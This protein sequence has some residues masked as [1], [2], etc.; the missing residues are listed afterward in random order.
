MWL[1]L[2][3]V[4]ALVDARSEASERPQRCE[5][6]PIERTLGGTEWLVYGCEDRKSFVVLSA[7]GNPAMPFYFV[8]TE[9]G[10]KLTIRG[11]GTGS[12]TASDAAGKELEMLIDSR[13]A[14]A[15]LLAETVEANEVSTSE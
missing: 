7:E 15:T 3:F 11:E 9:I 4:V 6:G 8:V 14:V 5:M 13:E 12:K 2:L 1:T 10:G